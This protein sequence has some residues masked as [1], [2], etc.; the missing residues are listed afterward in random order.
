[1]PA[2]KAQQA[3]VAE[4]RAKAIQMRLAG[5]DWD[6]ITTRLQYRDRHSAC[7]D[8]RRA[9][10]KARKEENESADTMRQLA[11]MR[12]ERLIAALM[13]EALKGNVRAAAEAGRM[14]E[15]IVRLHGLEAPKQI[16]HSGEVTTYQIVGLSPEELV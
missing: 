12:Y 16:E 1:M 10:D 7:R 15:R 13:P 9:L 2:S 4:R 3:A 5:V 8:V 11:G 14:T 6:T